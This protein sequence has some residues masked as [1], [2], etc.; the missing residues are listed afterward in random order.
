MTLPDPIERRTTRCAIY[1]RKSTEHGLDKAVNSLETQRDVCRAYIKCQ[2]HR[3]WVELPHR[4]DDGGYSGGTLVRPALNRLVA[5]IESGRIDMVVIYKIDRLTRSL[6]DFVRLIDV[7]EKYGVSFVSVT[8]AFDTSDSMGRLVLN[9]LLTF[10]QFEREL[11]SDRV[12]DKKAAMIRKGLFAGGLPPFGYL[13]GRGGRLEV[14]PERA[15]IVKELFDRYP[16]AGSVRELVSDLADRGC[17]TRRWVA[18][19]GKAKGGQPISAAVVRQILSNPLYAGFL[20][21]RGEW[22]EAQVAPLVTRGQWDEVQAVRQQ[23]RTVRDPDRDFLVGILHDELGRRM[24]MSGSAPGHG[25]KP[26]YYKA[27]DRS[28]GR[29]R[30]RTIFVDAA[31][32]EDVAKCALKAFLADRAGLNRALLSLGRY[33]D[34]TGRLAAR[35]PVAARRLDLMDRPHLRRLFVALVPRAELTRSELR[36]YVSCHELGRFLAWNG[37]GLFGKSPVQ[38]CHGGDRVHLVSAP[39]QAMCGKKTYLVPIEPLRGPRV[40]PKPWLIDILGR[41]AELRQFVLANR[42]KSLAELAKQKRMGPAQLSR[43]LRANYLAPDIQAAIVDGTQPPDL[44]AWDILN[45]PLPLD[46]EQQRQLLGFG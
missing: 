28:A 44:T 36:L 43:F 18:R 17:R 45:G 12:R 19:S 14:D 35:G 10:A 3:N 26:R 34:E 2:A 32:A 4:Y 7:L 13:V 22:I 5:D 8:Q 33:S 31:A 42:D 46:W 6:L 25:H 40:D 16:K 11:M 27:E 21:H 37:K 38:P 15:S 29:R 1:T 30:D 24:R 39:A 41:A 23:R 20:V 9:V